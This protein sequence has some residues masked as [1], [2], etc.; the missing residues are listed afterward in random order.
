LA[1]IC[2]ELPSHGILLLYLSASG[3]IGQIS[4]SPLSARSATSVEENIL[5][6]F[7]SHTIKQETEP[8]LQITPSGQSLRQISEDAV[9]TPCGLS[10]GSH[11]LT[12]SSYIYP[13]DLVPFTRKPL[14]IIID[15]DSS[16]VF[17]VSTPDSIIL[18]LKFI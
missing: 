16:T 9:S 4:S 7:E 3:K 11:G 18:M 2:E 12:G 14:F 13:S 17:K 1:T 10:F 15:S 6:D 5:R 8:S